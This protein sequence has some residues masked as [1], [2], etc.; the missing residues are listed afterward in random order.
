M[1]L[2]DFK[3]IDV[4]VGPS[5]GPM[6]RILVAGDLYPGGRAEPL[7]SGDKS[8]SIFDD[9]RDVF[10]QHDLRICDLECPL[11]KINEPIVKTGPHLRADPKCAHG[12]KKAGFDIVTLANNHIL[13]MGPTGLKDTIDACG[14]AGLLTIG[15]GLNAKE[16]SRP[17]I[18]TKNKIKIAIMSITEHEFS[19][20]DMTN[21]GASS[22]NIIDNTINIIDLKKEVDFILLIIHGGNEYYPLPSPERLKAYHFLADMGANAI[23][24][25]HIHVPGGYEI[26]NQIPIVYG[27][28]NFLYE[29]PD[30]KPLNWEKGYLISMDIAPKRVLRMR[31]IPYVQFNGTST[32]NIMR[33]QEA[34]TFLSEIKSLSDKI[35]QPGMLNMEWAEFCRSY[36]NQ[37]VSFLL[38]LSPIERK[39]LHFGI[40]PFWRLR[41]K[42]L[43][44]LL[45]LIQC[46]SHRELL[47]SILKRDVD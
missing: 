30:S 8:E 7:L 22:Y 43:H 12:I 39:L 13:D 15:A 23:I 19:I 35:K 29:I 10:S 38:N 14:N 47:L 27:T 6:A 3:N 21:A 46:E 24:S 16:A 5:E 20:A 18:V 25:H 9:L 36:R 42:K 2:N 32:I 45:N 28:G 44:L 41:K 34:E 11:T 26:Y 31:I 40:W 33:D 37:Y 17:A 4:A 1:P